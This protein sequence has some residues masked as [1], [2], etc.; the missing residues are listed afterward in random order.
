MPEEIPPGIGSGGEGQYFPTEEDVNGNL[1]TLFSE[2]LLISN[3]SDQYKLF[4]AFINLTGIFTIS[5]YPTLQNE[6]RFDY[7]GLQCLFARFQRDAFGVG[8]FKKAMDGLVA[9]QKMTEEGRQRVLQEVDQLSIRINTK[10]P[11]KT[12]IAAAFSL[13]MCAMRPA[14]PRTLSCPLVKRE[15]LDLYCASLNFWIASAYL[16]LYGDVNVH[17]LPDWRIRLARIRYD[18]TYRNVNLSSLEM[19]YSSIFVL[20]R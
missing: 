3:S 5:F 19:L 20:R 16:T 11:R 6:I 13:W 18:F 15:D 14:H 17:R 9:E 1:R 12:K 7:V 2:E 8:R 4:V 10:E